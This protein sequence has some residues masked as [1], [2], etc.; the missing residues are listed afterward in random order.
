MKVFS[1]AFFIA[2]NLALDFLNSVAGAG[3]GRTEF[4][5]DDMGV[6]N[7]L[8]QAGLPVGHAARA[9][10]RAPQGSLHS[11]AL[12]L[13]EVGR[14]LIERRKA[15]KHGDPAQLNRLLVRGGAYQKLLWKLGAQPQ[16][17]AYRRVEAPEDLLVP[18]AEAIAELLETG[19][20]ELVR[21]CENPD[22]TLWFYDRTKSHRRRWCSMAICGNRM[23]VAAFRVRQ[24]RRVQAEDRGHASARRGG[25]S[26]DR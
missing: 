4:L 14:G 26:G 1:P 24:G 8:K 20:Y 19:D 15:G 12:I 21:K 3:S 22:C 25:R 23:K 11:A 6:L 9:M 16:R 13:R 5:S 17:I 10:K 2:D 18:V 7:W